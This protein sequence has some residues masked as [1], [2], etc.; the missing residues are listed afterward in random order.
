M[1]TPVIIH[2][3]YEYDRMIPD[4]YSINF[5]F[6]LEN[7]NNSVKVSDLIR[8][9]I[10]QDNTFDEYI[11]SAENRFIENIREDYF[12]AIT[13][14]DET[15]YIYQS[16]LSERYNIEYYNDLFVIIKHNVG[17][18]YGG[19]AHGNYT[20]NYFIVDLT[21]ERILDISDLIYQIPDEILKKNIQ[22]EYNIDYFLRDNIWPPDAI[23]FQNDSVILLWNTYSI[24]PY[25]Y[26]LI[27]IKIKDTV[28]ES[29][30]TEKGV[31]LKTSMGI[32]N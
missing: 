31:K 26:G 5:E 16:S 30:F 4:N 10:Y 25:V 11:L 6:H 29:Y 12:P 15:G 24:T 17:I 20:T 7:I 27:E 13:D 19:A 8:K 32:K 14:N 23:S 28:I 21:D 2:K 9:L 22:E 3:D 1:S 18:Y